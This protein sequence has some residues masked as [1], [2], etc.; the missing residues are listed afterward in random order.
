[1]QRCWDGHFCALQTRS[2]CLTLDIFHDEVSL[3]NMLFQRVYSRDAGMIERR[4]DLCLAFKP[5]QAVGVAD[6]MF[7]Q[8]LNRDQTFQTHV[9]G[10]IYLAHAACA[11][12]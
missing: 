6:E 10:E 2:E 11:Q 12:R 7:G 5:R 8:C 9:P 4:D 1:L 3:P